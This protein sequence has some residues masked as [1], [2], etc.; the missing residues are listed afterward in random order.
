[1]LAAAAAAVLLALL[2]GTGVAL[3]QAHVARTQARIAQ[4]ENA[5]ASAAMRF[6][7]DTFAAT[8]PEQSLKSDVSVRQ[9]IEHAQAE[10]DKNAAV[11]PRVRQP[12]QRM[13]GRLYY[14]V[15][16]R[17]R[18]AELLSAGTR[19]VQPRNR[20]EALALADDL[21]VESLAYDALE[22]FSESLSASD[23]AVALRR[24]FA[25]D[26]PEQQL[27]SLANITLAHV[28]KF[29]LPACRKQADAALALAK[30]MPNPPT[31]VVLHVY[32]LVAAGARI[33]DDRMRTLQASD[34]GIAF[35][36]QHGIAP[37]SPL[38][39]ELMRNR[40]E[41]LIQL[42]QYPQA[43]ATARQVIAISDKTGSS[44]DS[45]IGILYGVL[46][47]ALSGQGRYREALA[48]HQ[49]AAR[50]MPLAELGP[51]NQAVD[52]G[53]E[54]MLQYAV[55]D[56]AKSLATSASA[57]G[58]L[59]KAY[60]APGDEFRT[61]VEVKY[62]RAL[63]ANG[64][65]TQARSLLDALLPRV[66]E[67]EGADSENYALALEAASEVALRTGEVASGQKLLDES[68]A[69]Y[70]KRGLAPAHVKFAQYLREDAAFAR[71]RGDLAV[72]ERLQREAL[73][74]L[75]SAG[76]PF[77]VA[78][79]RAELARIRFER[80]DKAQARALLVLA[81]P[82]MRDSVLPQQVDRAAAETLAKRLG[83]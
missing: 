44:G 13:L 19:G 10:L 54:A 15:D 62:A 33:A 35:A 2:A 6:I 43:E 50:F 36:D 52:L 77:D 5:N 68:R 12:V 3:W 74:R 65:A 25:P 31:D 63:L 76:N 48:S 71:M 57:V 82:V 22:R 51:R 26:D 14:S 55:G 18:A 75:Q 56:Y 60:I 11:D 67:A 27:R 79:A 39:I 28:Q 4:R 1:M 17:K 37:E 16:D 53:N 47:K 7:T 83:L 40:A 64:H 21:V 23:R 41:A 69:R 30:R 45:R 73:Q 66:R 49:D 20:A 59:D 80:G 38:R 61:P 72:A 78:V 24:Q 29:G 8:S 81:L 70:L 46:A 58:V 42:G 34:E 32:A 9:L